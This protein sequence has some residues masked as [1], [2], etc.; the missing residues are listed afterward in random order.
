M[1][2]RSLSSFSV[3]HEYVPIQIAYLAFDLFTSFFVFEW[4]TS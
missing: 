2:S 1:P 3:Y 4:S